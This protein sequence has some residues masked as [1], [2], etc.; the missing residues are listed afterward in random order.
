MIPLNLI[1]SNVDIMGK[2]PQLVVAVCAA[3]LLLAFFIGFAKGFRRVS[4]CWLPC[5]AAFVGF[6]FAMK[7]LEGKELP[8]KLPSIPGMSE[9]AL[10]MMALA[11]GCLLLAIILYGFFSAVFRPKTVW[12]KKSRKEFKKEQKSGKGD[13][14]PKKLVWKNS[15]PPTF[16]GRFWGAVL[17]VVNTAVALALVL[18]CGLLFINAIDSMKVKFADVMN[19]KIMHLALQYASKYALDFLTLCVPFFIACYGYKRGLA[20][21]LRSIITSAGGALVIILAFG[22]PF[23]ADT[24]KVDM[25][26]VAKLVSRCTVLVAKLPVFFHGI[27]SKL[28]AGVLLLIIFGIILAIINYLMDRYYNMI[29]NVKLMQTIDSSVSCLIYFVIGVMVCIGI[30]AGLYAMDAFGFFSINEL[31]GEETMLAKEMLGFVKNFM[32]QLLAPFLAA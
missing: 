20:G 11:F 27:A 18:A 25:G 1:L 3:I 19:I 29:K 28:I 22:L 12:V 31:V 30:W 21:S 15:A 14:N 17:C 24:L 7:F 32:D 10:I 4:W 5:L 6:I 13:G 26:I 16:Y 8:F 23:M 2:L 9:T